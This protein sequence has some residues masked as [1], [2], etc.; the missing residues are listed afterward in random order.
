MTF[1]EHETCADA[2]GLTEQLLKRLEKENLVPEAATQD[3]ASYLVREWQIPMY[4]FELGLIEVPME[5][6]KAMQEG[7]RWGAIGEP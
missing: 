2:E 5:D 3:D 6:L 1:T 4:D 7:T